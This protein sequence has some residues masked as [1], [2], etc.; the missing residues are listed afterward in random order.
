MQKQIGSSPKKKSNTENESM[1]NMQSVI[2]IIQ[3]T[4][5]KKDW[6]TFTTFGGKFT[7]LHRC[8]K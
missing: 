8:L 2:E 3:E 1:A 6:E 7:Q 5:E 4:Q